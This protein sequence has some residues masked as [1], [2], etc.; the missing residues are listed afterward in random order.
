M[1]YN[2]TNHEQTEQPQKI[3]MTKDVGNHGPVT[4]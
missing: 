3:N 1:V 4:C 2:S